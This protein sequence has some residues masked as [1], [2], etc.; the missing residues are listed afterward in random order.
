MYNG[1]KGAA[2][3]AHVERNITLA[4]PTAWEDLTGIQYGRLMSVANTSFHDGRAAAGAWRESGL[5]GFDK[6]CLP[7]KLLRA[8][9]VR[10]R[11]EYTYKPCAGIVAA[12]PSGRYDSDGTPNP[13]GTHYRQAWYITDYYIGD[14]LIYT[15][16]S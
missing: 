2:T 10:E 13:D 15:E 16:R 3:I 8:I 5:V 12:L 7:E 9:S 4:Y 14:M 11:V 6:I 1:H